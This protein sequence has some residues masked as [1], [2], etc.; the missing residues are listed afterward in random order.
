M[1]I[2]FKNMLFT[3]GLSSLIIGCAVNAPVV[4]SGKVSYGDTNAVETVNTDFG[5]TDLNMVA[6]QMSN[7][8]IASGKINQC[9][10]YTV[11]KVRNKTDQYIDTENITQS[12]VNNL[13][14]SAQVKSQYVISS[15]EMQNQVDELDRQNQSGL[16]DQ[17]G[18]A[19][20]GK[21]KGAQCR[22]DGYVSNISKDNGQ[23]KDVFYIFNMKLIDVEQGT[24]VWSNEKQIR[25]DMVK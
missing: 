20:M 16:Y 21:M 11:S 1:I 3:A 22:L 23:V 25:K 18:S 8:L 19:K 7:A 13:S 17:S 24:Q 10:T 5:S 4:G 9:K 6:Q 2:N 15:Q 14:N 12:I